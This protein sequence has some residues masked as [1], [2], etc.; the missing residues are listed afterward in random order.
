MH[1]ELRVMTDLN[2]EAYHFNVLY[3]VGPSVGGRQMGQNYPN[4]SSDPAL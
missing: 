3:T 2:F 1:K 4:P